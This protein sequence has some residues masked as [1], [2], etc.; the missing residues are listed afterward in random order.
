MKRGKEEGSKEI[1]RE[2]KR[3]GGRER[4]MEKTETCYKSPSNVNTQLYIY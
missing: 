1:A 2:A 3:E 4:E